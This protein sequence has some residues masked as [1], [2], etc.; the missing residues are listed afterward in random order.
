MGRRMSCWAV[1]I[2]ILCMV[3]ARGDLKGDKTRVLNTIRRTDNEKL[4]A[5]RET[6]EEAAGHI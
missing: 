2:S 4:R 3:G 1:W 6:R 5:C